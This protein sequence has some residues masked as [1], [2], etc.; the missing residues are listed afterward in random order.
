MYTHYHITFSPSLLFWFWSIW[1]FCFVLFLCVCV[2]VVKNQSK[3]NSSWYD[4][5]L[6]VFLVCAGLKDLNGKIPETTSQ[7]KPW[8]STPNFNPNLNHRAQARF[9]LKSHT[10]QR[11]QLGFSL[12]SL[13]GGAVKVEKPVTS[14]CVNCNSKN[15]KEVILCKG[16]IDQINNWKKEH[17]VA[18]LQ[19]EELD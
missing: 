11:S 19:E 12:A 17:P 1:M 13:F 5:P 18:S 10:N 3:R 4:W 15:E 6:I 16:T 14:A 8:S 2:G 7:R 9:Q